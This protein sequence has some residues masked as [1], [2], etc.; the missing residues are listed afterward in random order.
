M[1]GQ[2]CWLFSTHIENSMASIWTSLIT[3][4]ACIFSLSHLEPKNTEIFSTSFPSLSGYE[5][6][7]LWQK[8]TAILGSKLGITV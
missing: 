7:V 4:I 5:V 2:T 3:S 6:L 8:A 1:A